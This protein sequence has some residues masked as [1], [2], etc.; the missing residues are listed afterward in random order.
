MSGYIHTFILF[1]ITTFC[2]ILFLPCIALSQ[3]VEI[4]ETS[5]QNL[6]ISYTTPTLESASREANGHNYRILSYQGC[7]F[8]QDTGKP[9]IPFSVYSVGVPESSVPRASVISSEIVTLN[10]QKIYPVERSI[11][12]REDNKGIPDAETGNFGETYT[13]ETQ[14]VIDNQFYSRSIDYPK[15][16]VEID[17]SGYLREQ[18]IASLRIYPLQYNPGTEQVTLYKNLIINIDFQSSKAQSSVFRNYRSSPFE[19]VYEDTLINYHQARKWRKVREKTPRLAPSPVTETRYKLSIEKDGVYRLTY[20]YLKSKG[21][22]TD[23][24]DPR[25]IQLTSWGDSVPIYVEGYQD[26]QF[27]PGDYIEFYAVKMDSQYTN[28]NVYWL[29]WS[30]LGSTGT[31]SWM[32]AIKDGKPKTPD[33]K[34]PLAFYDTKHW[35]LESGANIIYD[36]LSK[37]TSETADHF[38]WS[39]MRGGDPSNDSITDMPVHLPY[40][41]YDLSLEVILRVG[42]QGVTFAR[43]ANQHLVEIDFNGNIVGNAQWEGQEEYISE[44]ILSQRDLYRYNWLTLNCLDWNGTTSATDPKWDVY[45]NWVEID[46]WREFRADKNRLMFS[47]ETYPKVT[48]NVQYL[49]ED[50]TNSNIEIFQI[51]GS[52]AIA[53]I[54][55]AEVTKVEP[56]E[57]DDQ[58]FT[59]YQVLFEDQVSQPTKYYVTTRSALL[60]PESMVKDDN[61][62]LH[63]P[64]NRADYIV[65]THNKFRESAE[66]LAEFRRQQGLDVIVVDV[67]NIYDEFSY[68]IFDPK[69]I[70][71]FLRYAYFN[72]DKIPSYV[73]LVGDAHWDYKYVYDVYYQRYDNYPRIYV[74]TYHAASAPFG[75]TA[76][77]HRFV[78]VSGDDILPDMMLGRLPV[79]NETEAEVVVDKIIQYEENP[80]RG[81]W[82]SRVLLIADDEKSKSGDEV[83]EDSRRELAKDYIPIGYD[84]VPLYLRVIKEPYLVRKAISAEINR[85]VIMLEY[86]GHGGAHSWADEYIFASDDIGKL[87]NSKRYPFVITTTCQN[88][89]FDNPTGGNK[90]IMEV[91]LLEPNAGAIACL[92]ATRLTYGQGNATFDKILYPKVFSKKPPILGQ[93]IH[94]AKTEFI[95]LGI[96]TWIPS[97]EQY[98]LF[99]DPATKLNLPELEIECELTKS[100]VDS[101]S[102]LELKS[103][104]VKRMK[105]DPVTGKTNMVTDTSFNAQMQISVV[106]PNNLDDDK[107]NDLPEQNHAVRIWSGEYEGIKLNIPRGV[108][109]GEGK[110]R[111]YANG[112]S[113][114]A[115]GGVTFSVLKPVIEYYDGRIVNDESVEVYTAIVDNRGKSGIKTVECIWHDTENWKWYTYP[116]VSSSAPSGTPNISGNWYIINNNIPLSRPGSSIEYK[117]RVVDSEG[118]EVL[119]SLKKIEVPIGVN[120]AISKIAVA[121]YGISYGYSQERKSWILSAPVENN[122]GKEVKE[123]IDVMFFEGNPDRNRDGVVDSEA[124]LLGS[125]VIDY[126]QW[127]HNGEV[128][129]STKAVV[130]LDN[131]LVSGVHQIFAWINPKVHLGHGQYKNWVEDADLNDN[132]A[133]ARFPINDFLVGNGYAKTIASSLDNSLIIDLPAG[134][135]DETVMSIT[136]IQSPQPLWKQPE[137]TAGPVPKADV[138]NGAFSIQLAS[139]VNALNKEAEVEIKFNA[140]DIWNMAKKRRGLSNRED[141]YLTRTEREWVEAA[142]IQE[143]N[144]LGIYEWLEDTGIWRYIETSLVMEGEDGLSPKTGKFIQEPYVTMPTKENV[145]DFLFETKHISVDE[146]TTPIGDWV[147]FFLNPNRYKL[148]LRR[149]GMDYYETLDDG[150]PDKVY[151]NRDV[152][153]RLIMQKGEKEYS[154]GDTYKF[155]TFQ[156]LD[157]TIKLQSLKNYISGDGTSRITLMT[158]E[159]ASNFTYIK[160]DWSIFFINS[161]EYE[162]ISSYGNVVRNSV[163]YP[164]KGKVGKE[165]VVPSIGINIE[166]YEGRWPFEFGD[167]FVFNTLYTGL[168]KA[169]INSLNTLALM[170]SEDRISPEIQLWINRESPQSGIV[171]PPKPDISI[172]LSDNNGIDVESL[173]F[174]VS[175]NDRDFY[176]VTKD[177]YV[178]SDRA[179]N[180]NTLTN[181]PVFYSPTL[182]IGKYRYRISVKDLNG[183]KSNV[184]DADY[185]EFMF[186]VEEKPDETPPVITVNLDGE[187]LVDGMML[188]KSPEIRVKIDDDHALEPST[189][190]FSMGQKDQE[191]V[192][193]TERDYDITISDDGKT[194][195]ILYLPNLMN[196]LYSIQVQAGDTSENFSS[197]GFPYPIS[198]RVNEQVE[199]GEVINAPN[200]FSYST[201]FTFSLNQPAERVAIKI[202]SLRGKLLKTLNHESLSWHYNEI[203]WDGRDEEGNRLSNGVYFYKF[204][205]YDNE[206]KIVRTGKIAVV[207]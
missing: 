32:M 46:Y 20:S 103:G 185:I 172:L 12:R 3:D 169:K 158:E 191:L 39:A 13:S 123:P 62:T 43:G 47:T 176:P 112:G 91:F 163:G 174:M 35:E 97:A 128:I 49:V 165:L 96:A 134:A 44:I 66:K 90:T 150:K 105:T 94:E 50:F 156:D 72:W 33:L 178:F 170:H 160:G 141:K 196:D 74:P 130:T 203:Y 19:Q 30:S 120:L 31:K 116:M 125:T 204:T 206:R 53:K 38:F 22:D 86:S 77:D 175:V 189:I 162:I 187:T 17:S 61:S 131:P 198:F 26:G 142:C 70:Q 151:E 37:V 186:L 167:R 24:I 69:A 8:T 139:G 2:F 127:E 159:D 143:A 138:D 6:V 34:P 145:S 192:V 195:E 100:S 55:N 89:Y 117:I 107:S 157:G 71:R 106:Y 63:D 16:I 52:S 183:N 79:E 124:E 88:G 4:L 164:I 27:D 51:D 93:I 108:M 205:L 122:G 98:T 182:N 133:S 58:G 168:V 80:Y 109:P 118:N 36:P 78:T 64:A 65:I 84:P 81:I 45:L 18:Y 29:S 202:Y 137:I 7:S 119:T 132:K 197:L 171:I 102:E 5:D 126:E 73:L 57:E 161:M 181:I 95:N 1:V 99:G 201:D 14:F 114:S 15:I 148:Y 177:D 135:V 200:P 146:I 25:K 83:F 129:Q 140:A 188:D 113:L 179:S 9:M 68:G 67:E 173:S 166:V 149:Q 10:R 115:I 40:R 76:M 82:Q 147:I 28:T 184:D 144:K 41:I 54:I 104:L 194:A 154:Y 155:E 190:A 56:N 152:G 199:L 193:L 87:Q 75:Q 101:S 92:S 136:R 110:L 59:T 23:N 85:G 121:N 180:V 60:T 48:K 111:C 207:R 42:F 21:I 153:I 11:I